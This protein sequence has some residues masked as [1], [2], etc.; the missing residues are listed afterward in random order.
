M[1]VRVLLLLTFVSACS[2]VPADS[3]VPGE[4]DGNSGDSGEP[5]DSG[6]TGDGGDTGAPE[7]EEVES[8]A[9]T[10]TWRVDFDAA[11]EANGKVDCDYTRTYAAEEDRSAPWLCP[12][13]AVVFRADA[14]LT[15]GA[16]CFASI[17]TRAASGLEWIGWTDAG[18]FRR[19]PRENVPLT[20]QGRATVDAG[21]LTTVNEVDSKV[22]DDQFHF[23]VEGTFTRGRTLADPLHGWRS[24]AAY[25]CGWPVRG[26]PA[27]GGDWTVA[28]GTPVPD[29]I[30]RDACGEPVRLH[31][32]V[33]GRFVLIDVSA[34]DC[35]PCRAMAAGET[36]FVEGMAAEGI[37]VEVVTLLAPTLSAV[38]DP[39]PTTLLE[40]WRD[41]YELHG[42]V[43]GDRGW[44]YAL[45][46]P[47]TPDGSLSYPTSLLVSPDGVVID[48]HVGFGSWTT[49]EDLLRAAGG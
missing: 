49:W 35:G 9:G 5:G 40:Q 1:S 3:G 43:L 37:E 33:G 29:G 20:E 45:V 36:A 25:A 32:L 30:F 39:T 7:L 27:Y 31:D 6:D 2:P 18:V 26:A 41:S 28:V 16:D 21:T 13:C 46:S 19:G 42:P 47:A 22:G 4:D 14:T 8:L 38:L 24:P 23:L 17:S 12:D 48:V 34:F 10:I 44:G 15:E 11:A